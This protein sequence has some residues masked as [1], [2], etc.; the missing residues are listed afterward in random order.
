M[1][2][3]FITLTLFAAAIA[4][5]IFLLLPEYQEYR[6]LQKRQEHLEGQLEQ[7][8]EYL[9]SLRD[10]GGQLAAQSDA[11]EKLAV[12]VPDAPELH[13]LTYFIGNAA[14]ENGV[15]LSN[16]GDISVGESTEEQ[17]DVRDIRFS[18]QVTGTY[19]A[20]R[21]FLGTIEQSARL[22][23]V[24]QMNISAERQ[25]I[26]ASEEENNNAISASIDFV[27]HTY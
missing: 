21:S 9:Q 19:S 4:M 25:G 20:L 5:G 11:M 27:T 24:N 15:L 17:Q 7:K 3:S 14:R 22:I 2:R 26:G 18:V 13:R 12:A 10:I 6:K 8:S 16:I 1:P 23:E